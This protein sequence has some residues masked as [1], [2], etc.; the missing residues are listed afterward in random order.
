MNGAAARPTLSLDPKIILQE[1]C[2]SPSHF[3]EIP[4]TRQDGFDSFDGWCIN[5]ISER[6]DLAYR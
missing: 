4:T 1:P 3:T 6:C 2:H 5:E